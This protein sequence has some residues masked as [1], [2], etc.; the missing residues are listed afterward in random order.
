[1]GRSQAAT[2][3]PESLLEKFCADGAR[4]DQALAKGDFKT[5]LKMY[6]SII[7]EVEKT[8][9]LDMAECLLEHG[10]NPNTQ[11][12]A[13]SSALF[14][15]H[16]IRDAPMIA[17]LEQH[18]ARLDACAVGLMGLTDQAATLLAEAAA[19]DASTGTT[20]R[21]SNVAKERG[22]MPSM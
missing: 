14:N 9:Q 8:G 3:L 13:A 11:V 22:P 16:Q 15:A 6:K 12:Y 21:V 1:M 20:S 17:L 5:A 18:G 7:D 4:A 19:G 10:A 2:Q